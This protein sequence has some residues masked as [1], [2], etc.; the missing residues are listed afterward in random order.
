MQKSLR[1]KIPGIRVL[2]ANFQ[3]YQVLTLRRTRHLSVE[4]VCQRHHIPYASAQRVLQI[5][6]DNTRRHTHNT[7]TETDTK[8]GRKPH[9]NGVRRQKSEERVAVVVTTRADHRGH[10]AGTGPSTETTSASI[11]TTLKKPDLPESRLLPLG[12]DTVD[13]PCGDDFVDTNKCRSR[14][15]MATSQILKVLPMVTKKHEE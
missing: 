5:Q 13:H 15:K 4:D 14:A 9:G 10:G 11:S 3:K 7:G 12:S 8:T 1:E 2:R 6:R